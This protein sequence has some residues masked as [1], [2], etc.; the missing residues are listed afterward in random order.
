MSF[1][2]HHYAEGARNDSNP[3]WKGWDYYAAVILKKTVWDTDYGPCWVGVGRWRMMKAVRQ[4]NYF[5]LSYSLF[6]DFHSNT[7]LASPPF[8]R[9]VSHPSAT[10]RRSN[11]DPVSSGIFFCLSF[12]TVVCD[13][14]LAFEEMD[15]E[16]DARAEFA[17]PF[18]AEDFDIVDL[19]CHIDEEHPVEAKNGRRRRFR[20]G[21]S[22][23]HSTL[24]QLRKEQ[25]EGHLQSH[26]GGSPFVSSTNAAPDPLSL[27]IFNLPLSD[28]SKDVEASP[29]DEASSTKKSADVKV[30]DSSEPPLSDKELEEK[31]RKRDFVQE[32]LLSTFLDDTL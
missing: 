24:S 31:A 19:F 16:D 28:T 8:P 15:G 1:G 7:F 32:L 12:W 17:C 21:S 4:S 25:R 5:A 9:L 14:Y 29:A 26:R 22:G 13:L 6:V 30:V 18:C 20:R 27:L 23:S 11:P 3:R 2:P 10:N